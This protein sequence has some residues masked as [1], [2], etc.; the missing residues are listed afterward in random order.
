[1]QQMRFK[2]MPPNSSHLLCL[3]LFSRSADDTATFFF[4]GGTSRGS[5]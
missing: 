1:M 3:L 5:A 2:Q 4:I